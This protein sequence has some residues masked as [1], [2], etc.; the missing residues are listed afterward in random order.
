MA[1]KEAYSEFLFSYGTLQLEAVQMAT[2]GRKLAGTS[3]ALRG[4][5]LASLKIEDP[6]V[7]AISGK[8]Y[9]TM[10][11]FT[12]HASDVVSGTLFAVTPGEIENADKYEVAAV[13]RV[14]VVLESGIRA[15]A[16]VDARNAPPD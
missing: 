1:A 9:H 15:W 2:F 14:A 3:D 11:R 16:Y 8:A 5:E 6:T 12:G 7:V 10:A 13:K 4:F